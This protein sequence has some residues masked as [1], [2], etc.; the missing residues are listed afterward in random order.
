MRSQIYLSVSWQAG[1][2]C[3]PYR[4]MHALRN[5]RNLFQKPTGLSLARPAITTHSSYDHLDF[6]MLLGHIGPYKADA[7]LIRSRGIAASPE[8]KPT[9]DM[10]PSG[11]LPH[12]VQV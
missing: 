5:D 1:N 6:W 4:R 11:S 12:M 7:F 8:V 2:P 10:R 3:L 9:S